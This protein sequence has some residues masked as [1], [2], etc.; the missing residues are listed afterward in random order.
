MERHTFIFSFFLSELGS[1]I[2]RD[3]NDKG[4]GCLVSTI[5]QRQ[6]VVTIADL[7]HDNVPYAAIVTP[8]SAVKGNVAL[9]IL[10][11]HPPRGGFIILKIRNIR[12]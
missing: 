1:D 9:H 4:L 11:T 10:K 6:I 3:M 8:E 12:I 5:D 7:V 2:K